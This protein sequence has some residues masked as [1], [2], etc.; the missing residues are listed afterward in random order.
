[1][2]K[3]FLVSL[4]GALVGLAGAGAIA[5][6][7]ASAQSPSASD[8]VI[9]VVPQQ[10]LGRGDMQLMRSGSIESFRLFINWSEVER[11]PGLYDWSASDAAVAVA[12]A[13]GITTLPFL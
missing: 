10:E 4:T 7:A 11:V 1:V 8:F 2:V 12:A 9:G 6:A 3:R 13:E 5:P